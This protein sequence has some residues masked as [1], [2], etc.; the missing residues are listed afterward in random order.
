MSKFPDKD[1]QEISSHATLETCLVSCGVYA[2][3]ENVNE[4]EVLDYAEQH[5]LDTFPPDKKIRGASIMKLKTT[6]ADSKDGVTITNPQARGMLKAAGIRKVDDMSLAEVRSEIDNLIQMEEDGKIKLPKD[7]ENLELLTQVMTAL[8]ATLPVTVMR[9]SKLPGE[10]ESV[11]KNG[12]G[13]KT[14]PTSTP[15]L[16]EGK[17]TQED[18]EEVYIKKSSKPRNVKVT[19]TSRKREGMSAKEAAFRV[20]SETTKESMSQEE[21]AERAVK[22]GYLI[23]R[24]KTPSASIGARLYMDI[25]SNGKKSRFVKVGPGQFTLNK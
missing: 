20:L 16:P 22:K 19:S 11:D 3:V 23:S 4:N 17:E 21:I 24:G 2:G 14:V 15:A 13:S 12:N 1:I 18:H 25:V 6:I 5:G 9:G 8:K 7:E 10:E